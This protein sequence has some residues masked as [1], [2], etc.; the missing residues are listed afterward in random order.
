MKILVRIGVCLATASGI[1]LAGCGSS[2]GGGSS[3]TPKTVAEAAAQ[4]LVAVD[5]LRSLVDQMV[6]AENAAHEALNDERYDEWNR[7]WRE[8]YPAWV[9]QL[10]AA[11]SSLSALDETL[12]D[13]ASNGVSKVVI[14][15]KFVPI[16]IVLAAIAAITF[17]ASE[18]KKR[19]AAMNNTPSQSETDAAI[20]RR[21]AYLENEKGLAPQAART[22]AI[23]DIGQITVL[24]GLKTGIEHARDFVSE[25]VPNFFGGYLPEQVGNALDLADTGGKLSDIRDNISALISSEGC[26][27]AQQKADFNDDFV[28]NFPVCRV[29]FC[30]GSDLQCDNV[31]AGD[32]D[33]SV[34]AP[35]LVRDEVST[36]VSE[37][38]NN[39]AEVSLTDPREFEPEPTPSPT[40]TP[41]GGSADQDIFIQSYGNFDGSVGQDRNSADIRFSGDAS[42]PTFSW[43]RGGTIQ[44][45]VDAGEGE[46]L[47][48]IFASEEEE[49]DPD[50][51]EDNV[52][53]PLPS[54]IQYGDYSVA[55][56]MP[57]GGYMIPSP[58]LVVEE[59]YIVTVAIETGPDSGEFAFVVFR[60]MR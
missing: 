17:I 24:Q 11:A 48:G 14:Q 12:R 10:D 47:Y 55:N 18:E 31:P 39:R 5:E 27:E 23:A 20:D 46:R 1:F 30:D 28:E 36:N 42:S 59:T 60:R 3:S 29:V 7:Y 19:L 50:T 43:S 49:N 15:E 4:E 38:G 25:Q 56:S 41:D 32:Y 52:T 57:L 35:G 2:G 33:V 34:F 13:L 58:A 26:G 8:D 37:S 45:H 53:I 22:R 40:A 51:S 6:T 21:A 44:I 16:P 54:T 9:S